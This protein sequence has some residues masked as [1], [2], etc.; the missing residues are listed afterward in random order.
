M[1]FADRGKVPDIQQPRIT[2]DFL[3]ATYM[4]PITAI[5]DCCYSGG[6]LRSGG[7]TGSVRRIEPLRGLLSV[8]AMLDLA[9]NH[10]RRRSKIKLHSQHWKANLTCFVQLA[11]CSKHERAFEMLIKEKGYGSP[12]SFINISCESRNMPIISQ[13]P[14][15]VGL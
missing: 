9:M 3:G 5:F 13:T 10:L 6:A 14:E 12:F 11:A 7:N 8:K 4:T 2:F 1:L 15:A